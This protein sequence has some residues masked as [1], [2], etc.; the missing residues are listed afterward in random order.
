MDGK[1]SCSS[2]LSIF[3]NFGSENSFSY[4]PLVGSDDGGRQHQPNEHMDCARLLDCVKSVALMILR[5]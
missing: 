1:G 3:L 2:D 4:R 5:M